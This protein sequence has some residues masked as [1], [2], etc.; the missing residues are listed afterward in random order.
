M[1]S[2]M[3]VA[4][5]RQDFIRATEAAITLAAVRIKAEQEQGSALTCS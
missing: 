1:G 4:L 5:L 2:S 3:S